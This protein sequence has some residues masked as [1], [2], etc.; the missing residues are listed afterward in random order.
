[1][2]NEGASSEVMKS[3]FNWRNPKT[4]QEYID[5][6]MPLLKRN[7]RLLSGVDPGSVNQMKRPK[8]ETQGA[9]ND[10]EL[11]DEQVNPKDEQVNPKDEQVNPKDEQVDSNDVKK[12]KKTLSEFSFE[13]C[14][15]HINFGRQ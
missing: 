7:A 1:M 15:V 10:E 14:T 8:M 6:S 11:H 4:A 2:A 12:A 5:N 13:N 3:K 9:P